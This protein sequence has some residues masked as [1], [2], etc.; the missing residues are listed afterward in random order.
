[1]GQDPEVPAA[2]LF[3]HVIGAGIRRYNRIA[4]LIGAGTKEDGGL[5]MSAKE[6]LETGERFVLLNSV[7][8]YVRSKGFRRQNQGGSLR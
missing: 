4:G 6:P 5:R 1:M 3:P 8:I 7:C 2:G